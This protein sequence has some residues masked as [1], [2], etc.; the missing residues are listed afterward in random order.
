VKSNKKKQKEKNER[1]SESLRIKITRKA[2]L[3]EVKYKEMG[4]G[5]RH[6]HTTVHNYN[7]IRSPFCCI[8]A[9]L[10]AIHAKCGAM[11]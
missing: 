4:G 3:L 9:T 2:G 5:S 8:W 6:L 11:V 7:G 1:P 10:T